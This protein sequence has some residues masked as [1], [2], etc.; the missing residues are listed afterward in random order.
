MSTIEIPLTKGKYAVIDK[1]DLELVMRLKWR[2]QSD[3]KYKSGYVTSGDGFTRLHSYIMNCPPGLRVDHINGNGLDNRRSNLRICTRLENSKNKGVSYNKTSSRFKG[4][5]KVGNR[6]RAF[7]TSDAIK[8]NLSCF[9]TETE[10]AIAYNKK[11]K[12]LHGEF[13]RLNTDP[14]GRYKL[15]VTFSPPIMQESPI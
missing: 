15:V 6:W 4:V 2:Y 14:P 13:A 10:A 5:Y 12:E 11:A 7:I 9:K 8:Y 3:R 1:D